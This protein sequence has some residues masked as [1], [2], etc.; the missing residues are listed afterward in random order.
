MGKSAER[1]PNS[2]AN[3]PVPRI[4]IYR[5]EICFNPRA[6]L[7]G[8]LFSISS[9]YIYFRSEELV[10]AASDDRVNRLIGVMTP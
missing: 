7:W 2:A 4:C 1:R 6:A 9:R 3:E 8:A 5:V 10:R